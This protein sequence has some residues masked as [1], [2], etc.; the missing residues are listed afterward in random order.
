[1]FSRIEPD[2]SEKKTLDECLQKKKRRKLNEISQLTE[3][4]I[5]NMDQ[6]ELKRSMKAAVIQW[7]EKLKGLKRQNLIPGNKNQPNWGENTIS[8][9]GLIWVTFFWLMDQP[10]LHR[11]GINCAWNSVRKCYREHCLVVH[12]WHTCATCWWDTCWIQS[13]K[14]QTSF[15]WIGFEKTSR[16][17]WKVHCDNKQRCTSSL[18]FEVHGE[19]TL[20]ELE[21]NCEVTSFT[22]TSDNAFLIYTTIE[23]LKFMAIEK[24]A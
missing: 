14:R 17:L 20:F 22:V 4:D 12:S 23:E 5:N 21:R 15:A 3:D 19:K 2:Q 7:Q 24:A 11:L 6:E 10:L 8:F 9:F 13:S 16:I 1:M 18:P